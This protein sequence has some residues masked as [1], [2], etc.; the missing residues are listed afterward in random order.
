MMTG[1][2]I[3]A[4]VQQPLLVVPLAILSHFVLDTFPHFGVRENGD[5]RERD[6]HPLFRTVLVADLVILFTALVAIPLL[7]DKT[8][9]WWVVALGMLAAWIPDVVWVHRTVRAH[10]GHA[11]KEPMLL[12]RFHQKIQ[13][14]ERPPGLVTEIVWLGATLAVLIAIAV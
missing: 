3:A 4:I 12:T 8:V 5:I 1:A 11:H 9:A 10:K 2:V 14:F 6:A 13:W 7:M